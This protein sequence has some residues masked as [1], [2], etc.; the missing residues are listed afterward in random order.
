GRENVARG[1]ELDFGGSDVLARELDEPDRIVGERGG[2]A[3]LALGRDLDGQRFAV[4][5]EGMV[6]IS[7]QA[8]H[9][10]NVVQVA[11]DVAVVWAARLAIEG[12]NRVMATVRFVEIAGRARDRAER[13]ID[14]SD[15]ERALAGER[16]ETSASDHQQVT[17]GIE[18]AAIV[19]DEAAQPRER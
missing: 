7:A 16:D 14:G 15:V 5:G 9:A 4:C 17:R 3:A 1:D 2:D 13:G 11:R 18:L 8:E 6:E 19:S 12:K 10:G